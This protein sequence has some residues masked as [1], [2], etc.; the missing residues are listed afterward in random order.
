MRNLWLFGL[1]LAFVFY[2]LVGGAVFHHLEYAEEEK[3]RKEVFKMHKDVD[4][5]KRNTTEGMENACLLPT[6]TQ[7]LVNSKV[8][9]KIDDVCEKEGAS[10]ISV[11]SLPNIL[12]G[13]ILRRL[14]AQVANLTADK[15][16][17]EDDDIP[18]LIMSRRQFE[19]HIREAY[20]AGQRGMDPMSTD[21]NSSPPQWS[22]SSA[23][24]FSLTVVTTIGYGHIAPSTVGGMAFCVVYALI[25]IPLYLVILDGVGTL[26][27]KMVRRIA[28]KAHVSHKWSANRVKQIAWAITFA[29]GLCLFYL[30]PAFI[31]SSTEDWTYTESLYYMFISLSTIGFGDYVVGKQM[32]RQYGSAYKALMFIWITCGL[33]F[34]AMVFD[35]MKRGIE[36]I[37]SNEQDAKDSGA[38]ED[39]EMASMETLSDQ[40]GVDAQR[41]G[42][43]RP[44]TVA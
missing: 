12:K 17:I 14:T 22:F 9:S 41:K 35:L 1:V 26:L 2:V 42:Q 34:L 37:D 29:I 40:A 38:C 33:V 25:G 36:S 6:S 18:V 30:L 21:T 27:G 3:I 39:Q 13:I 31:V 11:Q 4:D 28:Q 24:G 8:G 16:C 23:V 19:R 43:F 7:R 10:C 32:G 44:T 15:D 5:M 20:V